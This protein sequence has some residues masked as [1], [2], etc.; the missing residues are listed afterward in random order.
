VIPN[1]PRLSDVVFLAVAAR[2]AQAKR[3]A[4]GGLPPGW[5]HG[6]GLSSLLKAAEAWER[7]DPEPLDLEACGPMGRLL[8]EARRLTQE[9]GHGA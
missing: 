3:Q 6:H 5:E 4:Y 1:D 9:H 7:E 2:R 8:R